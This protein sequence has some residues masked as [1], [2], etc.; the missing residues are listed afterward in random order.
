[1][2]K[3][4]RRILY[5]AMVAVLVV[6]QLSN[7]L[8]ALA[9]DKKAL[10]YKELGIDYELYA[11]LAAATNGSGSNGGILYKE[12][13]ENLKSL[14]LNNSDLYET[15]RKVESF[16]KLSEV[17]PNLT[18]ISE[19]GVIATNARDSF[20]AEV[21]KL[22]KLSYVS[23]Y[24]YAQNQLTT[25]FNKAGKENITTFIINLNGDEA[26]DISDLPVFANLSQFEL[27]NYSNNIK[28]IEKVTDIKKL[29]SLTLR[30]YYG[31]LY[32]EI[33]NNVPDTLT[34]INMSYYRSHSSYDAETD[35][36][37]DISRLT[38][39][40][41][42][43]LSGF[44]SVTGLDK[45]GKAKTNFW[46]SLYISGN[47]KTKVDFSSISDEV[48][49]LN[50]NSCVLE[51]GT[52]ISKVPASVNNLTI[53]NCGLTDIKVSN[54]AS[55]GNLDVSDNELTTMP[56]ITGLNLYRLDIANN[57][58]KDIS[59]ATDMKNLYYLNASKNDIE[60]LPDFSSF[61]SL[62]GSEYGNDSWNF[63]STDY[64]KF[65]LAGNK[66]TKE[67]IKG[68]VPSECENDVFWMY[69]ATSLSTE[70][71]HVYY[72]T[73]DTTLVSKYIETDYNTI[74]TS[75]KEFTFD[76]ELVKYIKE[77]NNKENWYRIYIEYV[78]NDKV[79]DSVTINPK[80]LSDD[81]KTF[82]VTF[83]SVE[84]GK[85]S[86]ELNDAFAKYGEIEK[87]YVSTPQKESNIQGVTYGKSY[88]DISLKNQ[89]EYYHEY[90]YDPESKTFA[91]RDY[92]Y[93]G[94]NH[95][96]SKDSDTAGMI[97]FFVP[98][99]KDSYMNTYAVEHSD[100]N[101]KY[102]STY[103]CYTELNDDVVNGMMLRG[104]HLFGYYGNECIESTGSINIS[105][106]VV[107]KL[108]S[109]KKHYG[110]NV[111]DNAIKNSTMYGYLDYS[112]L[113]EQ[114]IKTTLPTMT[115][116][117]GSELQI[118]FAGGV[119][120]Y[121][122]DIDNTVD[123]CGINYSFRV[124]SASYRDNELGNNIYKVVG[125]TYVPL[126]LRTRN[127]SIRVPN[128][129]KQQVF[130]ISAQEDEYMKTAVINDGENKGIKYTYLNKADS[131]EIKKLY[132][133]YSEAGMHSNVN[134][135]VITDKIELDADTIE[136]IKEKSN[137]SF[138]R[139]LNINFMNTN[140]GE[141]DYT[142]TL[143]PSSLNN[144]KAVGPVTIVKPDIEVSTYNKEFTKLLPADTMA[145]YVKNNAEQV[146]WITYCAD[147]KYINSKIGNDF[148]NGNGHY[149]FALNKSGT[150]YRTVSGHG[151][152]IPV[153]N[154]YI[155]YVLQSDY[156]TPTDT[157]PATPSDTTPTDPTKPTEPETKPTEPETKPTQ[158]TIKEPDAGDN[159][160]ES[161]NKGE[162]TKPDT[163]TQGKNVA[164]EVV[165]K[166]DIVDVA[167]VNDT[168]IE[169]IVESKLAEIKVTSSAAPKLT[170]N[171]FSQ[172]KG[173]QKDITVGVTDE[174]NR[175]K[176]QWKFSSDTVTQT[177]MDI[178]L[179]ISFDTDRADAVK[180]I[181]GRD[182]VMYLSF[183]HHGALPGP[184]TIKTYV[185]N[186]YKDGD[187]VYLYYFNEEQNRVE[188][189]GG[190]NKG[191][192]VKNG[193]VEYTITHCSLY[194][195]STAMANDVNSVEPD[196]EIYVPD[197]V[198]EPERVNDTTPT[199][200]TRNIA[201][202][203]IETIIALAVMG[204]LVYS[205]KRRA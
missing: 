31:N 148:F 162:I 9:E 34:R 168:L 171:V 198:S 170:S 149:G 81:T 19:G 100:G 69:S 166:E 134:V 196:N 2:Q 40:E 150:L 54:A 126:E 96:I 56:D 70:S 123:G 6:L 37:V 132:N 192:V 12:D 38:N 197:A 110:F 178:D 147:G 180:E 199:G 61:K 66:L 144:Y 190:V 129:V 131:G 32:Q 73:I 4:K 101:N 94:Y 91:F 68:K 128:G 8:L 79:V 51:D 95:S 41:S 21:A 107:S 3:T 111:Y 23:V 165:A 154:Y 159:S 89:D 137:T 20:F 16:D 26:Y 124:S 117:S 201:V 130:V 88:I 50:L 60:T 74:Y 185:G 45:L 53:N 52:S 133:A 64:Y 205:K 108:I 76:E 92:V 175:L 63:F 200:D 15:A 25:L 174:N 183:A 160:G 118:P 7:A 142:A 120:D 172:M 167:K 204:G 78:D 138:D 80:E 57:K 119:P 17:C 109:G 27:A 103:N 43:D 156:S 98:D 47:G 71:G 86:K 36:S 11:L 164:P 97:Y 189:V 113:K 153:R 10:N 42:V 181:T 82:T 48:D 93:G 35:V 83:D 22:D 99:S 33:I 28:G 146:S 203:A 151:M 90:I 161:S 177:D 46:T 77:L 55:L 136:A 179:S 186:Q 62:V 121:V 39:L 141:C 194:F 106:D 152:K 84:E 115:Q 85:Y 102:T 135:N 176:Y 72:P 145:I 193:Y 163:N 65:S 173:K 140:S 187:V 191:L 157:T 59:T 67:A 112:L 116:K 87:Y 5:V 24:V 143:S 127:Y 139:K 104:A 49:N 125:Q 202:Y 18:Y 75:Q 1:M 13:A 122:Y 44:D 29:D 114:D 155:A 184:A 158:P 105:K 30:G 195:L 169:N 14:Y 188:S 182:D 58:I